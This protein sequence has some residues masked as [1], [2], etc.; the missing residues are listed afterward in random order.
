ML[1]NAKNPK[2]VDIQ[3]IKTDYLK[4]FTDFL[5]RPIANPTIPDSETK[6]Q[7]LNNAK[8]MLILATYHILNLA[9]DSL[10]TGNFEQR[11]TQAQNF[12]NP[13]R[14]LGGS[15]GTLVSPAGI[16]EH[17][18]D[19]PYEPINPKTFKQS[20]LPSDGY[21]TVIGPQGQQIKV[22]T[23]QIEQMKRNVEQNK[24]KIQTAVVSRGISKDMNGKNIYTTMFGKYGFDIRIDENGEYTIDI[25]NTRE[26]YDNF[27][28]KY[29]LAPS[30][31][32][33]LTQS[34]LSA[35]GK[36]KTRKSKFNKHR[37]HK[38]KNYRNKRYTRKQVKKVTKRKSR[39]C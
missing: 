7:Q 8:C 11:I 37:T 19:M 32:K 24:N 27:L 16:G 26:Q 21:T 12:I 38:I 17:K 22:N 18:F 3:R 2:G 5:N 31:K 23:E 13:P 15:N 34:I 14:S 6:N 35:G 9:G 4:F 29:G 28:R 20:F 36:R 39:R 25:L 33:N 30:T 1:E 10:P